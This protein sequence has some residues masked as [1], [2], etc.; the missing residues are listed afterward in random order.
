M[1]SDSGNRI[2]TI[3][4]H[5]LELK[6]MKQELS[7]SITC[8]DKELAKLDKE[9]QRLSDS[10]RE[11]R[12]LLSALRR[13]PKEVIADIFLHTLIFPFPRVQPSGALTNLGD[14]STF[15]AS[16]HPLLSFELVSRNWKDV[17]DTFP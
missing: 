10:V 17:L 16:R 1:I 2:D 12:L 6:M 15:S 4:V 13:M 14:W 9:R 8:V 5:V 7:Q 11:R 3:E